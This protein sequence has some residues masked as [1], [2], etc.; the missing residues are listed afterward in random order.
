MNNKYS[1][2]IHGLPVFDSIMELSELM[3]ISFGRLLLYVNRGFCFY[4]R[5][6]LEKKDHSFREILQ[7]CK[8]LKAIQAWILRNILDE[9]VPSNVATAYIIGR[10][11]LYHVRPHKNNRYFYCVDLEDFFPS[12]TNQRVFSLFKDIGYSQNAAFILTKLTTCNHILP[13]GAVTSP[14]ISNFVCLSMDRRLFGFTSRRNIAYTRYADDMTFSSNNRNELNKSVKTIKKI[15]LDEDFCIN[16]EKTRFVGPKQQCK[17]IGMV[18]NTSEPEFRI[19]M[20]KKRE[21]RAVLYNAI[22]KNEFGEKK[23][24]NM[25]SINGWLSYLRFVDK[26]GYEQML[27]YKNK[28]S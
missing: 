22:I 19:G 24:K 26:K 17:I 3:H 23:Y 25:N 12:I 18:K 9:L 11:S 14:A 16:S 5:C 27:I 8:E 7:P 28:I 6:Y 2:I 4:K 20:R 15:I 10:T 1:L 13:Q 21:M